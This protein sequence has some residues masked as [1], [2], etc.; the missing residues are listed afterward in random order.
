MYKIRYCSKTKTPKRKNQKHQGITQNRI[1]HKYSQ[2]YQIELSLNKTPKPI[3]K[4]NARKIK[5]IA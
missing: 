3:D 2:N 5:D 4:H 1:I